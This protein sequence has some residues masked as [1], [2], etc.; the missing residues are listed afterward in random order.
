MMRGLN[1]SPRFIGAL[2][3]LVEQAVEAIEAENSAEAIGERSYSA[4]V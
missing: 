3:D 4:G 1:D 2:A